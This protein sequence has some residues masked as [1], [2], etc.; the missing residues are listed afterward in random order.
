M[1]MCIGH[2]L[3]KQYCVTK[4]PPVAYG[5]SGSACSPARFCSADPDQALL[6]V[7]V[8][9][10]VWEA[11]VATS[12]QC[13]APGLHPK[14]EACACLCW[15]GARQQCHG[16]HSFPRSAGSR[17]AAGGSGQTEQAPAGLAPA[18]VPRPGRRGSRDLGHG[19]RR[20]GLRPSVP[21]ACWG[22]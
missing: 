2:L 3:T 12:A 13:P 19:H 22:C 15:A 18:D 5:E 17:G 10:G 4:R 21:S 7:P 9:A 6:P 8:P 11:A 20:Q 16:L 1:G 14:L